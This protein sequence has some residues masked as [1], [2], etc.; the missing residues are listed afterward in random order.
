MIVPRPSFQTRIS[1]LFA[2]TPAWDL[3]RTGA[4][5]S[6]DETA[7][8]MERSARMP[9]NA[10]VSEAVRTAAM[11]STAMADTIT[12]NARIF[13]MV[14]TFLREECGPS[15]PF[16]QGVFRVAVLPHVKKIVTK[17]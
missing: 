10:T 6:R 13:C 4:G 14:H 3:A 1:R 17:C 2:F 7:R 12:K 8:P 11:A 9:T 5:F 15:D 16:L